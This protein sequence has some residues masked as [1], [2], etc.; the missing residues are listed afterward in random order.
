MWRLAPRCPGPRDDA[1][2]RIGLFGV[3]RDRAGRLRHGR[4]ERELVE[5]ARH[6]FSAAPSDRRDPPF[7]R[8]E[9]G[10][11]AGLG[12][13]RDDRDRRAGGRRSEKVMREDDDVCADRGEG[14]RNVRHDERK[15]DQETTWEK[16]RHRVP[17]MGTGGARPPR[18]PDKKS[19]TRAIAAAEDADRAK[20]PRTS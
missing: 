15:D 19:T 7:V 12:L 6:D 10:A 4:Q 8:L 5:L 2:V 17:P 14:E 3:P 18:R 1:A 16:T 11:P 13:Y 9:V 20:P